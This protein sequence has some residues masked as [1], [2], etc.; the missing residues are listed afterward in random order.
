MPSFEI[1]DG[2]TAVA[3]TA[4]PVNGQP[5]HSGKAVFGVTNKS[6]QGL[7][8]RL[9]VV[10]QGEAKKEW[11][12]IEGESERRFATGE[13]QTVTVAVKPPAGTAAGA[14]KFRLRAVNVND[15]DNDYTE[16]PV[17]GFELKP[18]TPPKPFPWWA[19]AVA[20]GLVVVVAGL[21]AAY[22]L[23]FAGGATMP[24]VTEA[25]VPQ[26]TQTLADLK[27]DLVVTTQNREPAGRDPGTVIDQTPAEGAPLEKGA[28]VTLFVDPGVKVPPLKGVSLTTAAQ[29]VSGA[30]LVIGEV[31]TKAENGTVDE[32]VDQSIP[33]ATMV[34]KDTRINVVVR[35]APC[36]NR[37]GG[38]AFCLDD[39]VL[40]FAEFE[41]QR[42]RVLIPVPNQ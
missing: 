36:R 31:K 30:R 10:L 22:F 2:P 17:S 33:E 4:E 14:Y 32:V 3:L 5:V 16:S 1:P 12:A 28:A 20:A 29:R 38:L 24:R 26:A 9:S 21:A 13:T 11:F 35:T 8:G 6:G 41:R 7:A 27:L 34:A 23:V 37:P 19:V 18:V 15:P 40:P 42:E 39:R 25:T